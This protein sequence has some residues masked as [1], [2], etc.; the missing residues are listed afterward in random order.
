VAKPSLEPT[1]LQ[2]QRA[3]EHRKCLERQAETFLNSNPYGVVREFNEQER[4][5][6]WRAVVRNEVPDQIRLVAGECLQSMRSALDYL[7][8]QLALGQTNN[9]RQT[10]AFPIFADVS[11]YAKDKNRYLG[12]IDPA[13]HREFDA[14]QPCNGPNPRHHPLWVLHRLNNDNK[15]RL[16]NIVGAVPRGVGFKLPDIQRRFVAMSVG[17]FED[18]DEIASITFGE[19]IPDTEMHGQAQFTFS[20][21]FGKDTA[22]TGLFDLGAEIDGISAEIEA[23]LKRFEP[24]FP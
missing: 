20:I 9:P 1:R 13:I 5:Y 16:P 15:H 10:T 18:G 11:S 14:V 3:E 17:A 2:L 4:K 24:F 8:W 19:G 23:V 6:V 7:A 21:G 12:D 22:A